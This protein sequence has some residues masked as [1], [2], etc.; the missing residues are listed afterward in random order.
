MRTG[1]IFYIPFKKL[2]RE[3]V[4]Y[5]KKVCDVC[6]NL[7]NNL[8]MSVN[9][10]WGWDRKELRHFPELFSNI[11]FIYIK[12]CVISKYASFVHW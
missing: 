9:S 5:D 10:A 8:H 2:R 6:Q 3:D 1:C 7:R 12:F 11:N 4:N